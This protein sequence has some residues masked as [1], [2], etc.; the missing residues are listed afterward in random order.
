MGNERQTKSNTNNVTSVGSIDHIMET[1]G[2]FLDRLSWMKIKTATT[3]KVIKILLT[4]A[5][6]DPI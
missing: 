6:S 2:I 4:H 5:S 1:N 3:F